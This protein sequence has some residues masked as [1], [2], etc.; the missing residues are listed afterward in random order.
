[1][2][3]HKR[4]LKALMTLPKRALPLSL[5]FLLLATVSVSAEVLDGFVINDSATGTAVLTGEIRAVAVQPWDGGIL[6]G[7]SFSITQRAEVWDT[8][9]RRWKRVAGVTLHNLARLNNDG[10]VDTTFAP[11][12]SGGPVNAIVIQQ[13]TT[14]PRVA[15][16]SRTYVGGGFTAIAGGA[17]NGLAR[18]KSADGSLDQTFDPGSGATVVNALL[19]QGNR[20]IVV[21]GAFSQLDGRSDLAGS[22]CRN[23]A[24]I[25][26][27]AENDGRLVET[28]AGGTDAAVNALLLQEGYL[29]AGGI[30][31]TPRRFLARFAPDGLPDSSFTAEPAGAVRALALQPDRMILVGG[32]FTSITRDL[33]PLSPLNRNYL[34]RLTH[35][36]RLTSFDPQLEPYP[37]ALQNYVASVAVQP[38]GRILAAGKF[39]RGSAQVGRFFRNLARF[40]P[41][42]AL[43][44]CIDTG[45]GAGTDDAINSITLEPNGR[46]LVGGKFAAVGAKT[47]TRLAR[48]Y[49]HGGLDDDGSILPAALRSPIFTI[50]LVPDGTFTV[51]GRT[52]SPVGPGV[53][54]AKLR[55][56][57]SHDASYG[58]DLLVNYLVMSQSLRE[59]GMMYINGQFFLPR[60]MMARVDDR[61]KLD[62][63]F[64]SEFLQSLP[65]VEVGSEV[66]SVLLVPRDT[67]AS[68][69]EEATL[70]DGLMYVGGTFTPRGGT[71]ADSLNFVKR[72]DQAGKE[73]ANFQAPSFNAPVR[74]LALQEDGKLLVGG[75]FR[76]GIV[77]LLGNGEVDQEF[78]PWAPHLEFEYIQAIAVQPDQKILLAG[79]FTE[80]VSPDDPQVKTRRL[81][82]VR[83]NSDGSIDDSF[84]ITL[85]YTY[86][87]PGVKGISLLA[88]G[89]MIIVGIFDKVNDGSAT[90]TRYGTARIS[91]EGKVLPPTFFT[92]L[93]FDADTLST[94]K[95]S[96]TERWSSAA[97]STPTR[98]LPPPP[99]SG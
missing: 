39:Q 40:Q 23:V 12:A 94:R 32:E 68:G 76:E 4:F 41:D 20:R 19:L 25:S 15:G 26:I 59:D 45:I 61:G 84:P 47:R 85:S 66:A 64:G 16:E 34:A 48:F 81:G 71:E 7:G 67:R 57:F 86:Y 73:D 54:V 11:E 99:G 28:F 21:G 30:F 13:D 38:D 49:F 58:S 50:T 2:P 87:E 88:D 69:A 53:G 74:A 37:L 8:V 10:T 31:S 33:D 95:C 96:L 78:R 1:M 90:H 6:I 43:D 75:A 52:R 14:D 60:M 91:R 22:P 56:D 79:N 46:F 51:T 44:D 92:F 27:A 18:L 98:N 62:Q 35:D 89:G 5:L 24:G 82:L 93:E 65:T 77:R 97:I 72:M 29:V 55:P 36:G 17:R 42:G 70:P 9:T 80:L 83:L 3:S 63:S